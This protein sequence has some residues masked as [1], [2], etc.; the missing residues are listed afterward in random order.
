[1]R[2]GTR[3][4]A[5][6]IAAAIAL[7]IGGCASAAP[8]NPAATPEP[9]A[10]AAFADAMRGPIGQWR[11][12]YATSVLP[13]VIPG[14][15]VGAAAGPGP[16]R[17]APSGR[18]DAEGTAMTGDARFHIGSMTKLF[19]AALI[20]Q[21]DQE[22]VLSVDDTLDRWFPAAPNA[23]TI[24]VGMLLA[25]ESGLAELNMDLV[26]HATSQQIVDDVFS[27]PPMIA[28]GTQY[29]YLNAGYIIL[30][31]IAEEATGTAYDRLVDARFIEPLG[32]TS[33]YLDGYGS[34]PEALDGFQITCAKGTDVACVRQPITLAAQEPS[35]QWTGAWSA[36]GMVSTA[37]DEAVWLRDLVAGDVLDDAHEK[38]MRDLTPLSAA[39]FRDM[40]AA[41]GIPA[42]Q[43]GEG[44]GLASF[45]VPGVGTCL[46]HAGRIPGANVIATYCP[47]A[48]LSIAILNAI[49][50]AGLTPGYP[51]LVPLAPAALAA[52]RD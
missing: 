13:F 23:S 36:G 46:G 12:S 42:V 26:G 27:Q 5:A 14:T 49:D 7:G 17:V 21:L 19:T 52:L 24:T 47:E 32:L 38:M 20:L 18:A 45:A 1:M 40:Y 44:M 35:P 11:A 25:H 51:G 39:S 15:V 43:L 3:L 28:P 2:H 31:R 6:G 41:E 16:V 30:G 9:T 29:L 22:G 4:V 10:A 8:E 37:R 50:P 34:G 33:T 48:D